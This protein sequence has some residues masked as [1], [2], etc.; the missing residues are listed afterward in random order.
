[1][2]TYAFTV[3]FAVKARNL[4]SALKKIRPV[5]RNRPEVVTVPRKGEIIHWDGNENGRPLSFYLAAQAEAEFIR[6]AG[7]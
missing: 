3:T 2:K 1:M 5:V 4:D 6:G 7:K